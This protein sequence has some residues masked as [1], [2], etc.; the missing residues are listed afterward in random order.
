M[1]SSKL[2][3]SAKAGKRM[4]PRPNPEKKVR[5]DASKAVNAMSK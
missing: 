4:V 5:P 3:K 1:A 2:K